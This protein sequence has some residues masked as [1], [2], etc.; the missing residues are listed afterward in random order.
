MKCG[1]CNL[2]FKKKSA[3]QSHLLCCEVIKKKKYREKN[4][5]MEPVPSMENMYELVKHLMVKCNALEHE[6]ATLKQY[7]NKKKQ[8]INV[9]DWLQAN[10]ADTT[11]PF[12]SVLKN[13]ELT[14]DI[15]ET[16]FTMSNYSNA[17]YYIFTNIFKVDTQATHSIRAFE[18]KSNSIYYLTEERTWDI[19]PLNVFK[20]GVL[21]LDRKLIKLFTAWIERNKEGI[22][23]DDAINSLH[24]KYTKVIM[25]D[26][27]RQARDTTL[28]QLYSKLYHY[29]KCNIKTVI[30]YQYEF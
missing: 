27:G 26:Q 2:E 13:T 9:V 11:K 7:T 24:L 10:T 20:K 12:L 21:S 8:K 23:N 4:A 6:V 18:Q 3:Y 29:L 25:G 15:L 28:Q 22:D 30:E 5:G 1:F 19:L 16:V 17:M 14:E